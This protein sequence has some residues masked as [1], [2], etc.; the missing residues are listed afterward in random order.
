MYNILGISSAGVLNR[1]NLYYNYWQNYY[2][3]N[4]FLFTFAQEYLDKYFP[5][6]L[7]DVFIYL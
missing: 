2:I 1:R 3:F 7:I 6:K 5:C 4:V